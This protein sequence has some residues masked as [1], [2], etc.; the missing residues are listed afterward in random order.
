M[1]SAVLNSEAPRH[2]KLCSGCP[3]GLTEVTVTS[4]QVYSSLAGESEAEV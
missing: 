1:L 4:W 3:S 2:G